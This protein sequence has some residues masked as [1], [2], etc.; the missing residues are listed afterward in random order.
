MKELPFVTTMIVVRNEERYIK[1]CLESFLRQD[2]PKDKYEILVID[3]CSTDKTIDIVER[4]SR[5][6]DNNI[7]K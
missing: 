6:K 7:K 5:C 1:K 2:Y 4:K 3:G